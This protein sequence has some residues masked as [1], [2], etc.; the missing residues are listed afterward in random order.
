MKIIKFNTCSVVGIGFLKDNVE[1]SEIFE[2]L[3]PEPC[4]HQFCD[5]CF[6]CVLSRGVDSV[7]EIGVIDKV[8]TDSLYNIEDKFFWYGGDCC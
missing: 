5:N 6:D 1:I 2:V 4:G 8:N 3:I 7:E